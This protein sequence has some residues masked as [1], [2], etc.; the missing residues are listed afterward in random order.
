MG[1]RPGGKRAYGC[2]DVQPQPQASRIFIR[3]F[4][5]NIT[6]VTADDYQQEETVVVVVS[7]DKHVWI[8]Q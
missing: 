3:L 4:M 8:L 7:G 2:V 1:S 6:T 5:T